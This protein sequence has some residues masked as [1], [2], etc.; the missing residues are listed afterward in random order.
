MI[1]RRWTARAAGSA[2]ADAYV[3]HFEGTVRPRLE[4]TNGFLGARLEGIQ[5]RGET[6]IV[7]VTRWE[8]MDAIR[9][10][11]GEDVD[12]RSSSPKLVRSCRSTT[13][14]CGTSSS[15]TGER[16]TTSS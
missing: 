11:A 13:T 4:G 14:G 16:S 3:A 5:D 7:I 1:A 6:E 2:Q 9:A 12:L 15:L 8:S 10:F